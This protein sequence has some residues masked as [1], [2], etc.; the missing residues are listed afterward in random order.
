MPQDRRDGCALCAEVGMDFKAV[1]PA[2]VANHRTPAVPHKL[3]TDRKLDHCPPAA[4]NTPP[5]AKGRPAPRPTARQPVSES[6]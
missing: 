4:M 5:P 1:Q 2:P 3:M 6:P